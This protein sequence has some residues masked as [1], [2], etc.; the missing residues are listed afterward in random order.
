[1]SNLTINLINEAPEQYKIPQDLIERVLC[2]AYEAHGDGGEAMV[3]V[4][5][6]SD[7]EIAK[8]NELYLNHE[9]PTDVLSF[10]DGD[11]EDG[12]LLLGD[13]AVSADTACR[14]AQER[15]MTFDEELTLYCL[16]GLLHLLGMRDH[17]DD[18][19]Q[20]MVQAQAKE[21]TRHGL[22]YID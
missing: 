20:Q 2:G 11:E 3:N 7:G 14:V 13:I 10:E 8:M 22:R 15:E 5:L 16:H 6:T 18:L 1:M 17:E 9:G 19:R 21:F 4:L 12:V